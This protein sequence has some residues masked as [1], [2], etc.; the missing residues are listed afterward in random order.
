MHHR[1][2]LINLKSMLDTCPSVH[3][4][5][6][7]KIKTKSEAVQTRLRSEGSGQERLLVF[8]GAVR[9]RR[10]PQPSTEPGRRHGNHT[11]DFSPLLGG[12]MRKTLK[13]LRTVI[14]K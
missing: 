5:K 6:N 8:L 7:K 11:G 14:Q 4:H 2:Y 10:R 9:A 1:R 12:L 13:S 3:M